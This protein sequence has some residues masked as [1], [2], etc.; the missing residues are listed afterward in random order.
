[1]ADEE[2]SNEVLRLG[3]EERDVR[4]QSNRSENRGAALTVKGW[5]RGSSSAV[6]TKTGELW[7]RGW[8][9]GTGGTEGGGLCTKEPRGGKEC[10]AVAISEGGECR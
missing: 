5:W 6:H 2:D 9:K 10:A 8:T 3:E 7:R 4:R 1:M